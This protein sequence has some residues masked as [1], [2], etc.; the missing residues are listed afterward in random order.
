[1]ICLLEL[2]KLKM[3]GSSYFLDFDFCISFCCCFLPFRI[4]RDKITPVVRFAFVKFETVEN[5]NRSLSFDGTLLMGSRIKVE[6]AK[7]TRRRPPPPIPT[8]QPSSSSSSS[9]TTQ[10][11]NI[12]ISCCQ[13]SVNQPHQMQSREVAEEVERISSHQ[14]ALTERDASLLAEVEKMKADKQVMMMEWTKLE[15]VTKGLQIVQE[16]HSSAP[17][18]QAELNVRTMEMDQRLRQLTNEKY[19][20]ED[21]LSA[22]ENERGDEDKK[23]RKHQEKTVAIKTIEE[24]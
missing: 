4:V 15:E 6:I 23:K 11:E 3:L 20:L 19:A 10:R 13:D 14:T 5:A 24:E 21:S 17:N 1:M 16:S 9:I 18:Y 12:Q 7:K 2:V 22:L 8:S